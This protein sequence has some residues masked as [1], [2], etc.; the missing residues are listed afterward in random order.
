[1][2]PLSHLYDA[3][4][5]GGGPAGATA[6]LVMARAG[7]KVLVLERSEFPRFHIGESLLPRN[8]PL[9]R[10]LGL[11]DAFAAIPRVE[12]RGA[13]FVTGDGRHS[14]RFTFDLGLLPGDTVT[15]NVERAPFDRLLLD[16]ARTAGAEVIE[17]RAVRN[18]LRLDDGG[19]AVTTDGGGAIAARWVVDASGQSTLLGKH[20]GTRQ[21]LPG[22]RKIAY[23][24]HFENVRRREGSAGGFPVIAMC[25]EG[26]FWLIPLDERRTSV[27]LVMDTGVA[28]GLG[29]PPE[30][31]LPWAISRSPFVRERT[32][33]AVFPETF[34]VAADFTYRCSP[35]AGPGYFLVGDAA[36]FVDP[37][38]STGV[39][40]GMMSGARAAEGI[41]EILGRGADPRRV[42]E[43]YIR[44]IEESS[45]PFFR[46]VEQYY[47]HSFRELLLEGQGPLEVHR[48]VLSVLAGNVF[49]RPAFSLRWRL[50]LFELLVRLNRSFPLVTRRER[51]SLLTGPHRQ[52]SRT[53]ETGALA[54]A[55]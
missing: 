39:C 8:M 7:L 44:F 50:R 43:G 15:Y 47:D 6:A 30:E 2:V 55:G 20:L 29:I 13:E 22:F 17:G 4:V 10:E 11:D 46:L 34:H 45:A 35:Y 26:W 54:S 53:D 49:P 40:L 14:A 16:A 48:A 5:I 51:F 31:V 41:A 25:E 23:F 42:R 19:V 27:G 33:E 1:M 12:K 37:I 24:G 36:T 38:F 52:E 32:A 21:V 28:S 9:L 18:L 3:L